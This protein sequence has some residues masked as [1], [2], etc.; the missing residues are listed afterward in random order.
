MRGEIQDA[1][2][3]HDRD[4]SRGG[5]AAQ[6][7]TDA[8]PLPVRQVED[9]EVRIGLPGDRG[10]RVRFLD[11]HDVVTRSLEDL[12]EHLAIRPAIRRQENAAPGGARAH[13]HDVFPVG[14]R[15]GGPDRESDVVGEERLDG[16][17]PKGALDGVAPEPG[18]RLRD[19][20]SRHEKPVEPVRDGDDF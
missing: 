9:D 4:P 3:D 20:R 5:G 15:I 13:R 2:G 8:E 11:G 6:L 17:G 16:L 12:R 14:L 10:D 19:A 1:R 18:R 7:G